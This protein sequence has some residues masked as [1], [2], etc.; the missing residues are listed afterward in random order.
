MAKNKDV[1]LQLITDSIEIVGNAIAASAAGAL[2]GDPI[3]AGVAGGL[4]KAFEIGF[5][6]I[7]TEISERMIGPR[8]KIRAG[9]VFAYAA[10][11]IRKRLEAN[12]NPR[13]DGFFDKIH[14]RRSAADEVLESVILKAQRE[15]E[16]RKIQY[17]SYLFS[18]IVFNP[19]IDV[20]T[21][22]QFVKIA[23]ELTYRHLC[24]MKL[25]LQAN[26][27]G[28]LDLEQANFTLT[29]RSVIKDCFNLYNWG[30]I[31]GDNRFM[32][33]LY[34]LYAKGPQLVGDSTDSKYQ[35]L[36]NKDTK[37]V[38]GIGK[39]IF[40]LMNLDLIPN[41]DIDTIVQTFK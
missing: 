4:G 24:I 28:V 33:R 2:S 40:E 34:E 35:G 41:E 5:R 25:S 10:A 15:P 6:T 18:N 31:D 7:G 1:V 38:E 29:F 32:Y 17:M 36:M 21:A 23:E 16:E 30:Y 3:T 12:E 37:T 27:Y 20:H 9:A 14:T 19:Q 26:E 11:D 13:D 22:H 8:E 39:N